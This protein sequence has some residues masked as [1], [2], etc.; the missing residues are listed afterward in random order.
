[1]FPASPWR[2]RTWPALTFL[3]RTSP[4]CQ[5]RNFGGT[6]AKRGSVSSSEAG[7]ASAEEWETL[8]WATGLKVMAPVGQETMH[9][10]HLTQ[11]DSPMGSLRSKAMPAVAPLPVL[12]STWF[13]MTSSQARTQRSQRTQAEWST[14]KTGEDAS[15]VRR[16]TLGSATGRAALRVGFWNR[17]DSPPQRLR[18]WPSSFT[19]A[20]FRPD[21]ESGGG[22]R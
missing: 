11:L 22:G 21:L 4:C 2:Q 16:A 14:A 7:T 12:P 8:I 19:W 15:E 5:R 9:S 6:P 1:M 18:S 17:L 13:S 20:S 3:R 10:P